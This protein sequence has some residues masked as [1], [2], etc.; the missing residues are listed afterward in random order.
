MSF[1][2]TGKQQE[3][4]LEAVRMRLLTKIEL[5]KEVEGIGILGSL[6]RGDFGDKSDIDVFVIIKEED[7]R[8]DIDEIWYKRVKGLIGDLKRDITVILY[9]LDGLKAVPTWHTIRLASEG[10]I[11]YDKGKVRETFQKIIKKAREAGLVEKK[12]GKRKVWMIGRPLRRGELIEVKV[13]EE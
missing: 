4:A 1:F 10:I 6:A 3:I 2:I 12:I 5:L 7:D 11:A 13:S 8:P 9:T